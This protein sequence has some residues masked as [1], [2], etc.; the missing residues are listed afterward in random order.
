M[1][2]RLLLVLFAVITLWLSGATL[3]AFAGYH[4]PLTD[5]LTM[6]HCLAN[7]C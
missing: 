2:E 3:L 7:S 5:T 6:F 4:G 1:T